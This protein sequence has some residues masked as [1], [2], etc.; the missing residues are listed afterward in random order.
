MRV[1]ASAEIA[2]SPAEVWRTA[3]DPMNDPSWCRKVRS[4]QPL[5]AQRWLV[6]HQ[7]I[8]RRPPQRLTLEHLEIDEPRRLTMREEDDASVFDVEYRL[9]PTEGGTRVTQISSFEWKTPPRPLRPL[10][11]IG[12]WL[13]IRRQLKDLKALL[14]RP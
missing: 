2:C 5:G 9:T 11:A 6:V 1:R 7:P 8:P 12:V 13:D 14:E 3:T 10:L 4:V